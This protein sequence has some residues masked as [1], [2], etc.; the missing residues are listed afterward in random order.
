MTSLVLNSLNFSL[1]KGKKRVVKVIL[2]EACYNL[3]AYLQN[4][5]WI[6]SSHM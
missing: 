4:Q 6:W 1:I 2:K 5:E 3:V